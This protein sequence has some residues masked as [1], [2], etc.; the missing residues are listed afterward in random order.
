MKIAASA[1]SVAVGSGGALAYTN[2][3]RHAAS[4][5]SKQ[6]RIAV[7]S[8]SLHNYFRATRESSFDRPGAMLAL[9]DL[10]EM[11]VD[12]YK[13]R[14]LEL[15]ASQFPSTEPAFLKELKYAMV[16]SLTNV[17]NLSVDIDQCGPDGAFSDSDRQ[18]RLAA[19][20]AIKPWVDIAHQLGAKSVSVGPG[21]VDA[22]N[23]A[24]TADSYKS[25][26]TY[27]L[28]KGI[29]VIVENQNGFGRE[30]PEDLVKLIKLAGP[31]RMGALPNLANFSDEPTRAR[32]LKLLFP[33]AT[34]VCHANVSAPDSQDPEAAFD[35]S[36]AIEIAKQTGFHGIYTIEFNGPGDPYAGIQKT[37]DELLRYI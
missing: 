27:A 21:K 33:L 22:E 26:A 1:A 16:H 25:L 7:S 5:P 19:L 8:W 34:T 31:G 10:P 28:S 20:E 18:A 30:N 11:I 24:P 2:K 13:I 15:C 12:R 23:L 3:H 35:F 14:H 6:E 29:H 32:G 37:L 17:V 9:L 36:P 4:P